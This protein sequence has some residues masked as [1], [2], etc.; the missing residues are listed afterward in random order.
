MRDL[1]D[2]INR[3]EDRVEE[4]EDNEI[5]S[6]EFETMNDFDLIH[7]ALNEDKY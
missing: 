5:F 1:V 4:I 6:D 7:E 2:V 3:Q